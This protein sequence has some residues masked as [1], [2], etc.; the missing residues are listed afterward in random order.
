MSLISVDSA[1]IYRGMD[2]GTAK[3][4]I[5]TLQKYPHALVNILEPEI[6]YS[7]GDFVSAADEAVETA[8]ER[9]QIPLLVGGTMLYLRAFR[10]GIAELPA[11][12]PEFRESLRL[13]A[14]EH[15]VS[16]LHADLQ[17]IDPQMAARIHPNN[18]PRIERA[19]EVCTVSGVPMSK[20][21]RDRTGVP[22]TERLRCQYCE[23]SL[24]HVPREELHRRI[25]ARVSAMLEARFADEV[26]DLMARPNL[27]A[28]AMSMRAVGYRQLWR[29]LE[30]N[31]EGPVDT[32]TA[33]SIVAATR[34]LARRQ[35]TWL[36][37]WRNLSVH[38]EL[39]DQDPLTAL[40]A[41]IRAFVS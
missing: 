32:S 2:I 30:S 9:G 38:H 13:K 5:D 7:V 39:V 37:S 3:P 40:A 26:R 29:Y 33:E 14:E 25:A 12:N 31:P 20:L 36:R 34:Q 19:L 11:R 21:L 15:G 17:Q 41:S 10:E 23:Y 24:L 6:D 16:K 22:A 18:Y 27:S 28:N 35:L 4:S 8:F 1:M